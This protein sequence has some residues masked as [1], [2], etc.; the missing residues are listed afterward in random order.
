MSSTNVISAGRRWFKSSFSKD[1]TTC[2]EV[3]FAGTS[4]LV[5]DSKYQG[6]PDI[7][8]TIAIPV[9]AWEHFLTIAT[10]NPVH[11]G[12]IDA[13][14]AIEHDAITGR[15]TVRDLHGT[16]LAYTEAEWGAFTA[17][18]RAGEFTFAA[19]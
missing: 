4:V 2:V 11:A 15:T 6:D 18:I 12:V 8:P 19:A 17:G 14:P 7:Q 1:A 13:V 3:R 9:G 16:A 10:D 5:R